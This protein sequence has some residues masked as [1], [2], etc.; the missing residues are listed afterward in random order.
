LGLPPGAGKSDVVALVAA[1]VGELPVVVN[2]ALTETTAPWLSE[3]AGLGAAAISLAAPRGALPAADGRLV[4]GRLYGPALLPLALA[5][6]QALAALGLPVIG[7]GG[8][9]TV[10]DGRAL[11]AAGAVAVQVDT[12]LWKVG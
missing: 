2:V 3:L 8:V 7:G 4:S 5:A 9:Y 12:V 10:A 1:A 11:L 6:V